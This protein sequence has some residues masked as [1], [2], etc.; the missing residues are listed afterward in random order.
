MTLDDE[1]IMTM[2]HCSHLMSN[3][4]GTLLVGD[5]SDTPVDVSDTGNHVVENDP[6]IYLFDVAAKT[7]ARVVAHKTSWKVYRENRQVTHPHPSF[8]PDE[9]RVCIP[10]IFEGEPAL[11]LAD[12]RPNKGRL[13]H[14]SP[15]TLCQRAF[16]IPACGVPGCIECQSNAVIGRAFPYDSPLAAFLFPVQAFI[17]LIFKIIALVVL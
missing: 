13:R 7:Y 15:L 5:G 17:A 3:Y 10:L 12:I 14:K 1:E 8:T 2:P 9:K 4:D 6:F 11:Y 16:F